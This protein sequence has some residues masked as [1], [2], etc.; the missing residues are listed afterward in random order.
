MSG[1]HLGLGQVV[2]SE[3]P[4]AHRELRLSPSK[5]H[6]MDHATPGRNDLAVRPVG[7]TGPEEMSP[8]SF[9]GRS[10]GRDSAPR[11]RKPA[12]KGVTVWGDNTHTHPMFKYLALIASFGC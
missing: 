5:C 6:R 11:R 10:F 7:D 8:Y 12:F 4:M 2:S 9:Q 3:Q 1:T